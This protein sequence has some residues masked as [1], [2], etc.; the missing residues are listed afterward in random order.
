MSAI[1][2][3]TNLCASN[4]I[5]S[6]DGPLGLLKDLEASAEGGAETSTLRPRSASFFEPDPLGASKFGA[7]ETA[8]VAKFFFEIGAILKQL[9]VLAFEC[10]SKKKSEGLS[11]F[12]LV[13][14]SLKYIDM[15]SFRDHVL[16][17]LTA[18]LALSKDIELDS[19]HELLTSDLKKMPLKNLREIALKAKFLCSLLEKGVLTKDVMIEAPTVAYSSAL[20]ASFEAADYE[21]FC[22]FFADLDQHKAISFLEITL[23]RLFAKKETPDLFFNVVNHVARSLGKHY[24][25][26]G[27]QKIVNEWLE[28][29]MYY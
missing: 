18:N 21:L 17:E 8:G 20:D 12:C 6:S 2:P 1:T 28:K 27:L 11:D 7:A 3:V 23:E 16:L 25:L 10:S 29:A 14:E 15:S 5:E 19:L 4:V 26:L 13:L 22:A 9:Q 24:N